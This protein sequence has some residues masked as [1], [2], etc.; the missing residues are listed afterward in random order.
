MHML[1]AL[2]PHKIFLPGMYQGSYKHL[3]PLLTLVGHVTALE[4]R[5][6]GPRF[7]GY[8]PAWAHAY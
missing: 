4:I 2:S 7:D 5:L 8:G 3:E 6:F 1:P